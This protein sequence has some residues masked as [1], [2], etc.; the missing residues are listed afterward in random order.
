MV[1]NKTNLTAVGGIYAML[2]VFALIVAAAFHLPLKFLPSPAELPRTLA[3]A[4]GT[5]L[6]LGIAA[7]VLRLSSIGRQL[8]EG[9]V[10]VTGRMDVRELWLV[11]AMS[12]VAEEL[13][14][15]GVL[16]ARAGL[17]GSAILFAVLHLPPKRALWLWA[18]ISLVVGLALGL[19][20]QRTGV[21][22][23]PIVAHFALSL[24]T[25]RWA[26]RRAAV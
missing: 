9:L 25:M 8:E 4:L 19:L 3:L 6:T 24:I 14:F 5:A 1:D 11:A 12:A 10:G 26:Q 2:S 7:R 15:R 23:A 13:L 21:L 20:M 22:A 17:I 16:L 18:P